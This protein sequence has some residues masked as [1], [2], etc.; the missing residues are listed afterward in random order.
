MIALSHLPIADWG[1]ADPASLAK[2]GY[3]GNAVAY[4]CVRMVAEAA[5]S[6]GFTASD[7]RV[8]TLL[9]EPSPDE[10]G[11]ALRE[12][13]YTDLQITG[14][15]WLE[16]I[17]LRIQLRRLSLMFEPYAPGSKHS[18]RRNRRR[19]F[20]SPQAA[21]TRFGS[22]RLELISAAESGFQFRFHP[23]KCSARS[24]GTRWLNE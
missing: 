17:T 13:L 16:A 24:F 12:R 21:L 2:D 14:N 3:I 10:A 8:E 19:T 1:R 7:E 9:I 11:Q 15:A 6:I 18:T 4:R 5:A 22:P 20:P 23:L